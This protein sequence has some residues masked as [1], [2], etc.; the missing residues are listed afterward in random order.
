[1]ILVVVAVCE[2]AALPEN[3]ARI[4]ARAAPAGEGACMIRWRTY[5]T[6]FPLDRSTAKLTPP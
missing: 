5:F 2:D 6:V 4:A 3:T 1:M